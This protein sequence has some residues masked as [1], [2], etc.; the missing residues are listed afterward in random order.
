MRHG[1]IDAIQV[2]GNR[3]RSSGKESPP[4]KEC[5]KCSSVVHSAYSVC[6]DYG[7][8]F[9]V[10]GS[11]NHDA[12]ASTEDI[13]SGEPE[14]T[15]CEVKSVSYSVHIKRSA[16]PDD[17]P[18]MRVDYSVG[19]QCWKSEWVCF[20]H[21]GYAKEKARQWWKS[22]SNEPVPETVQDAVNLAT[23]VA[24][25][26]TLQITIR[27][28]PGRKFESIV[29]YVLGEKPDAAFVDEEFIKEDYQLPE[30]VWPEDDIPF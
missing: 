2:S 26:E 6:P 22:R 15:E 17:P 24:L 18:T 14:D 8:E 21:T 12:T 4:A 20:E 16:G 25:A 30:Y 1:P 11:S 27:K 19:W 5:P 9:P 10:T 23:L 3:R 13:I 29:G 7:Y 28:T